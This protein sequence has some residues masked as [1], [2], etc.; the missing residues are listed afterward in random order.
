LA[1]LYTTIYVIT[2]AYDVAGRTVTSKY[3]TSTP[4]ESGDTFDILYDSKH[5]NRNTGSDG[6]TN[7]WVKW[8]ARIL[9][10]VATLLAIWLWGDRDW[11]TGFH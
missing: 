4:K 2:F 10:I 3:V 6:P 1:D 5:P 11:F 7:P 9:G 8:A